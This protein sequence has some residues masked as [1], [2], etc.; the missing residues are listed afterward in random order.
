MKMLRHVI[1]CGMAVVLCAPAAGA[2]NSRK[3][4][5]IT[6]ENNRVVSRQTITSQL[7]TK[8]GEDFSPVTL[9]EDIKRLYATGL[10][11]DVSADIKDIEGGVALIIKVEEKPVLA[12]IQF[13]G[14]QRLK[15]K[16]L[17]SKLKIKEKEIFD[18]FKLK[19]DIQQLVRFYA[20][21]GFP[22]AKITPAVREQEKA[23]IVQLAVE[24]GARSRIRKIDFNDNKAFT[25][26]RLAKVIKTKKKGWFNSGFLKQ[27]VL[28]EDAERVIAFYRQEGY[29][30]AQVKSDISYQPDARMEINFN[31]KEGTQYRVRQVTITGNVIFPTP[32]LTAVL[33]LAAG[34]IFTEDHL[35]DDVGALQRFYF[36][37]GYIGASV[38]A[39]TVMLPET[40]K[41]DVSFELAES[42][43]AYVD[44]IRISGNTRSQEDVIRRE[45][46]LAP[47]DRYNGEKLRRSRERLYNLGYFEEVTFDTADKP[48]TLPDKYDMD[49]YVKESKTGE[50]SFGAGYSSIDD[51]VGFVDLTQRNFDL[52]NPPGFI[53]AGQQLRARAEFGSER[54][55]YELSFVEPWFLGNPLAVGFEL[56]S[57]TREWDTYT[58]RRIGGNAFIGKDLGEYWRGRLTGQREQVNIYDVFDSASSEIKA[59]AGK[60][61][62]NSLTPEIS[63]DTRDNVFNPTRGHYGLGSV[64]Y[65]GGILGGDKDLEKYYT[66]LSKYVSL[67]RKSVLEFK[68]QA[69]VV[70]AFADT[71]E[72]PVYERFYAGGAATIRGYEEREVGPR[73]ENND[74]VGGELMFV[75]NL[76]HTYQ[77]TEVFKWALFYDAGNVWADVDEF[78][79]NDI[80][81][82]TSIGTGIRV[83][84]PLGPI[85]LDYVYALQPDEFED[86]G[87][88]HFSV[89]QTF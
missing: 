67:R 22:Q 20:E 6:V 10:F 81:L 16:L 8:I 43:M 68:A 47:G 48:T 28:E 29:I 7:Q 78:D 80:G 1:V 84:T 32:Q 4:K 42:T 5:E 18:Q 24:E 82:R 37:R 89:G 49:V 75:F 55:D 17:K 25:D 13:S 88:F 72:V 33:S 87:R 30:D 83:K 61:W 34:R 44:R 73:G 64:K 35:R 63:H 57:R 77:L 26:K 74:P 9:S 21:K 53:G 62:I 69:G 31:I 15:T 60:N 65:A 45:L 36:D 23:V 51:F 19:E 76:E 38:K 12:K 56:Y 27:E 11:R 58:E 85:R 86:P 79:P 3:V 50:F 70:Q 59:E 54:Q 46:K 41:V 52:F 14:N 66:R 40:G 71:E 2:Q 39:N